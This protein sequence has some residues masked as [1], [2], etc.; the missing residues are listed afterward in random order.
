MKMRS[1]LVFAGLMCTSLVGLAQQTGS[2]NTHITFMGQSR[3]LSCYVPSSYDSTQPMKLIVGLHGLGDNSSNYR[4]AL[5]NTLQWQNT[6]SN[7]I[8]VFPD[9]GSDTYR[10]FYTPAGD[11]AIITEAM[12]F[13]MS[14]YWIDSNYVVL[15]GFSLGGR[16]AAKFGL[17]NPG[18]FK[19]LLLNTPAFQG[20][21]DARNDPVASLVYNYPN[22]AQIPIFISVGDQDVIYLT[23]L[24]NTLVKTLKKNDAI[25]SYNPVAGMGHSVPGSSLMSQVYPFFDGPAS[26]ALD[27]DLFDSELPQHTCGGSI[28]PSCFVQNRS[29]SS[30]SSI[31]IDY[32]LGG[33]SG[34]YTWN[35]R[36]SAWE[37]AEITLPALS[38]AAGEQVLDLNIGTINGNLTDTLT[39]N[40]NLED[41]VEVDPQGEM[42]QLSEDFEGTSP[43]WVFT[44]TGTLFQWYRDTD[45]KK[46][47]TASIGNFNTILL[48][49]TKGNVESFESPVLDLKTA[50][51]PLLSFDVAYNYHEYTAAVLG[52]DT[53]FADTLEVALSTDCGQSWQSLYKKGGDELATASTPIMNP[54]NIQQCFFNP[55]ATEWRKD[56][57]DLS[58]FTNETE[59]IIRF[60]YISANGGS[61]NIDNILVDGE[62]IS[63]SELSQQ[64]L[65]LFPNPASGLVHL[66]TAGE[67]LGSVRVYNLAGSLVFEQNFDGSSQEDYRMDVS[68][69]S[70]GVYQVEVITAGGSAYR[71]LVVD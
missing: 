48:F 34:S 29:D 32:Q 50:D 54:L 51:D 12:E 10:D 36:L 14:N 55:S 70:K 11:E 44:E 27:L 67:K 43:G 3:T 13:A 64:Q 35:G 1:L 62:N 40:N 30:I 18:L 4:N 7:T 52:I 17:E 46:S 61:I 26:P 2:F 19:G 33:N 23:V 6:F 37:H 31:V 25:I 59:V 56:S 65:S 5:F 39:A 45:V 53:V 68:G 20:S 71:K 24:E 16:S 49:Y 22:A 66:S 8:F 60:N 15:Q 9:G 58:A 69:F 57:I 38:P 21:L 63:V 42:L 41:T 28:T 47:G